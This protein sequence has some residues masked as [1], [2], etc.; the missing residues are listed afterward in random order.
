MSVEMDPNI[1]HWSKWYEKFDVT[2]LHPYAGKIL[3]RVIEKDRTR[4]GII[5]PNGDKK[6]ATEAVVIK[7]GP[8][9]AHPKAGLKFP[10]PCE[11]GDTVVFMRYRGTEFDGEDGVYRMVEPGDL[12]CS[13]NG[14][15]VEPYGDRIVV[16][17]H[18]PS[19]TEGGI[20][21]PGGNTTD[22]VCEADVIK[23][24][25]GQFD[26]ETGNR[27]PQPVE[28]GQR[29]I[30]YSKAGANIIHEGEELRMIGRLSVLAVLEENNG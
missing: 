2:Q 3:V 4:G 20:I 9:L 25:P 18:E 6:S 22:P 24:G 5:L 28:P 10:V 7:I 27:I 14:E 29:V 23:V 26:A 19:E 17:M 8:K 16:R 11:V 1:S 15:S 30:A 13:M 21:L 12:W